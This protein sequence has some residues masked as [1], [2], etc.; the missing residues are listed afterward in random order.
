M[1]F[2]DSNEWTSSN[3]K[4]CQT[5]NFPTY[6]GVRNPTLCDKGEFWPIYNSSMRPHNIIIEKFNLNL[7]IF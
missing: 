4:S 7:K 1:T 3:H 6:R 2:D 5:L